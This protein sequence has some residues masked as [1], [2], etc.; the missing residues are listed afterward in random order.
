VVLTREGDS[1]A[2]VHVC[3]ADHPVVVDGPSTRAKY[4]LGRN[5]VL[6]MGFI[7]DYLR[8]ELG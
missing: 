1:S 3:C 7:V 6:F 4:G 2:H 5:C 8:F